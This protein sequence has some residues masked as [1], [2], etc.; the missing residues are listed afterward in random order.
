ME[1]LKL[2]E[3]NGRHGVECTGYMCSDDCPLNTIT[4]TRLFLLSNYSDTITPDKDTYGACAVA[5]VWAK[6]YKLY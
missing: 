2:A 3:A 5:L 6:F 4:A 1:R